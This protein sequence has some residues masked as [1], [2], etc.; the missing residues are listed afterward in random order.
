M[1]GA[2]LHLITGIGGQDGI[3]LARHLLARGERVIGTLT[4]LADERV[5]AHLPDVPLAELDVRA[6]STFAALVR[7]HR[8]DVVHNLAALSSVGASWDRPELTDEV[9]HQAVLGM[10]AVT[11]ETGISFVQ[12]SS[13]EIFGPAKSG[14]VE[15][16]TVGSGTAKSGT[17]ESGTVDEDTPLNPVSPYAEAKARAHVAV[18]EAR[19]GGARATNLILFGHTGPLH[20]PKFVLP[21][22]TRQAAATALGQAEGVTLRDPS[23]AR[24]WGSAADFVRAFALAARSAYDGGWSGDLVI[25]TGQLHRLAD[26]A[27][28]AVEAAES[29]VGRTETSGSIEPGGPERQG[30]SGSSGVRASGETPRHNDFGGVVGDFSRAS[31]VLGWRPEVT[32]RQTVELMVRADLARLRTGIQDSPDHLSP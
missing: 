21:T 24:D 2:G 9:N 32:L 8:P 29:A 15:S 19:A 16:G 4:S 12:A 14:T 11:G 31:S 10:L 1:T 13:S 28:W 23:V 7:E 20:D 25:A 26:V 30:V 3:L 27:Q 22:I 18:A 5:R 17:V 6:T